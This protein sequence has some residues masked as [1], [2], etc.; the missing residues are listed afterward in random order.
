[1]IFLA[2]F[3]VLHRIPQIRVEVGNIHRFGEHRVILGEKEGDDTK[4]FLKYH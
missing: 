4:N 2:L 1:M 3:F